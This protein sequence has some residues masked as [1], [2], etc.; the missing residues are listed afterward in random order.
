ME[1]DVAV[2]HT[3]EV[4]EACGPRKDLAFGGWG[5]E[6]EQPSYRA[7]YKEFRREVVMKI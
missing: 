4:W 2:L 6:E 3:A 5:E 1:A 7:H